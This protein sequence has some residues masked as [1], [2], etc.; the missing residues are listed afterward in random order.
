[1]EYNIVEKAFNQRLD[2]ITN[3]TYWF[4]RESHLFDSLREANNEIPLAHRQS[5]KVDGDSSN[6]NYWLKRKAQVSKNL[7]EAKKEILLAYN[8]LQEKNET[9]RKLTE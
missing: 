7:Q 9:V 2:A 8:N 3:L 1:M 4:N 6:L 5:M